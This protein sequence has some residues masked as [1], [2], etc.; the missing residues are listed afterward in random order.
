MT[1]NQ[2]ISEFTNIAQNDLN[3]IAAATDAMKLDRLNAA[4]REAYHVIRRVGVASYVHSGTTVT[5][6]LDSLVPR[7]L[8]VN[9]VRLGSSDVPQ[10]FNFVDSGWH[11]PNDKQIILRG[12]SAGT[13]TFEGYTVPPLLSATDT[14][15]TIDPEFCVPIIK[16]ALYSALGGQEETGE[17]RTRR[18]EL[19]MTAKKSLYSASYPNH[20]N[21]FK[22]IFIR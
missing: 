17:Q 20:N 15:T 11:T 16:M 2:F 7:L 14:E 19:Y 18:E 3:P 1:G 13:Y 5:V 8:T 6:S 12:L 4:V 9:A 10:S 21:N 22:N